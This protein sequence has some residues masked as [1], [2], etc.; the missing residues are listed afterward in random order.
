MRRSSKDEG[1]IR[2]HRRQEN[3]RGVQAFLG[4]PLFVLGGGALHALWGLI[5]AE[6]ARGGRFLLW[7]VG[8]ALCIWLYRFAGSRAKAVASKGE[9]A[10]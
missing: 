3:W 4:L 9:D 6:P 10:G 5:E 2:N 7:C 1:L 8:V